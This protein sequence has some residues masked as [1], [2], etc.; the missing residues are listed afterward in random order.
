M[1]AQVGVHHPLGCLHTTPFELTDD[2][3]IFLIRLEKMLEETKGEGFILPCFE[4]AT[5]PDQFEKENQPKI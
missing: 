3:Y 5:T 2:E 4:V 1:K